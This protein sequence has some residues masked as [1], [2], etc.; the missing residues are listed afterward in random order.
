M[1][2]VVLLS[3]KFVFAIASNMSDF[4][5]L[6]AR[7]TFDNYTW[8]EY[9][10]SYERM[11]RASDDDSIRNDLC[12]TREVSLRNARLFILQRASEIIAVQ[13]W[14]V[15]Q[16]QLLRIRPQNHFYVKLHPVDETFFH[17]NKNFNNKTIRFNNL[18]SHRCSSA[19]WS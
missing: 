7:S 10:R 17:Y 15:R 11:E 1:I 8:K 13:S 16:P 2:L 5:R 12:L 18:M 4:C 14:T 6:H 19:R 9:N 3:H